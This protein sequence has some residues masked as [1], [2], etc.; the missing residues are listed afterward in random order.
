LR[1]LAVHPFCEFLSEEENGRDTIIVFIVAAKQFETFIFPSMRAPTGPI[2]YNCVSSH[3]TDQRM[4]T[5][6]TSGE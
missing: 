6:E 5:E 3:N 2:K 1:Y 4:Q